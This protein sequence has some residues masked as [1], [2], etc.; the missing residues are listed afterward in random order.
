MVFQ[1]F[2]ELILPPDPAKRLF[3]HLIVIPGNHD[4][5]LWEMARE[6][7]YV[8]FVARNNLFRTLPRQWHTT[9]LFWSPKANP[10][11]SDFLTLMLR[12]Y[13]HLTDMAVHIAY[14]ALGLLHESG[15]K[16]VIFD[17][18]HFTEWIYWLMSDVRKWFFPWTQEPLD[19]WNVE[20]ENFA[21]VDFAWSVL[22]RSGGVGVGLETIYEKLQDKKAFEELKV[23]L[24]QSLSSKIGWSVTDTLER[25]ALEMLF[26]Y[27]LGQFGKTERAATECP[28]SEEGITS[29]YRYVEGPIR[30]Y[31]AERL[32]ARRLN[33]NNVSPDLLTEEKLAA[34]QLPEVVFVYGH[35]HKPFCDYE[36]FHGYSHWVDVYNTGGWIVDG[37]DPDPCY[38][39]SIVLVDEEMN[40]TSVNMYQQTQTDAV[41]G[42]IVEEA[43]RGFRAE[44]AFHQRISSLIEPDRDP[45]KTFSD[46]V[47]RALQIRRKH[48]RKRVYS[49]LRS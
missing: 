10:V 17:H 23:N 4:H 18:G 32:I 34:M 20:G 44:N 1:R 31:I 13:P 19:I 7:Q 14:P 15:S 40:V 12:S 33:Q 43:P 38:G 3:E 5:H 21:W 35:T 39:A 42:V 8:E 9:D 36:D 37:L 6:T 25:Q 45:W 22:G 11:E 24:A 2:L 46:T 30:R 47:A 29:L 48:L 49:K 41:S 28:L 26:D 27:L 16:C